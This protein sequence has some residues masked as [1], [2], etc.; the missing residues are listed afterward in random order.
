MEPAARKQFGNPSFPPHFLLLLTH[1]S[2]FENDVALVDPTKDG[3]YTYDVAEQKYLH[4]LEVPAF[5]DVA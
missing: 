1:Y 3:I 2:D 5:K 4:P